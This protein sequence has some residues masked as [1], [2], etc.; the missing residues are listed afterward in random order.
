[1]PARQPIL[2]LCFLWALGAGAT[3][4][5]GG[6][7]YYDHLGGNEYRVVM[8]LYRDCG[9][10]NQN[11]TGFDSPVQI[12]FFNS[13]GAMVTSATIPYSGETEVPVELN[14]P[15]LAAPPQVCVATTVYEATVN[16]PPIAGGYT[17]AYHRCCRTPGVD[18]LLNPNS[19]GLTCTTHIPGPPDA[20]NSSPRF[21]GYPSIALCVGENMV[22]DHSATD[23][24]GDEL[25][26]ELCAPFQGGSQAIPNPAPQPPPYN[27]V[28]WGPGYSTAFQVDGAP[29]LAID[30]STGEITVHPT[31]QG[32]YAVG[33][34][35]KEIRNGVQIGETRRDFMFKTVVCDANIL[36]V[37]AEQEA[38]AM[39]DLTQQFTNQSV[40]SDF[41][42][43]DFGDPST[44]SDTSDE[45]EPS[46][47]YSAPGTY[48]VTLVAN[49]GW[50][51]ADT[52]ISVYQVNEPVT[53]AFVPPEPMC[54]A[55]Q[56]T[57]EATG[58]FGASGVVDWDLGPATPSVAQ[59]TQVTAMFPA[60]GIMPVTVTATDN[61]CSATFTADVEVHLVPQPAI[62]PQ[63]VFC[64][65]LTMAF[66]NASQDAATYAWDFGDASTTADVSDQFEP[67]W[68][69]AQPGTYTVTLTGDPAGI[70]PVSTTSVFHVYTSLD[71]W[72]APAAILCPGE[73]V[74]IA[75]SGDLFS[76]NA[77]VQ[78]ELGAAG[79]PATGMAVTTSFD[80]VGLHPV[81]VTVSENGCTGTYTDEVEVHPFPV[82]DFVSSAEVCAGNPVAFTNTSTAWTPMT[83]LW[84]FG[85]G[86]SATAEH[87]E[88]RYDAP[89]L[90]TVT[91]TVN[92]TSGCIAERT[93]V[94]PGQVR[95]H[96]NPVAAFTALPVT[97]SILDPWIDVVDHAN[98]AVLWHYTVEESTITDPSFAY[99]FWDGGRFRIV[100][101]V[102]T[103]HGCT[104]TT[105]R[106]VY[107]TDH[108]FFAPNAFTPD[109]DGRNDT[110]A[111]LVRGARAYD[112][113]IY[114][115]W[116]VERF[117]TTDPRAEWTGDGLPQ[118]V[119][120]YVAR[121]S[122]HGPLDKQYTGHVTLLR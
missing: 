44:T 34:R 119:F 109:G 25:V 20:N 67:T 55:Q 79:T 17:L 65:S 14:N 60:D 53:V 58:S 90:F 87:P 1:M 75:V 23:P 96:P 27:E 31:M 105:S 8:V 97:V 57:L 107:V 113:V 86:G 77:D 121:I 35:V 68:T 13:A 89:G 115:R 104:D 88:H 46:W 11:Q 52:S 24:D 71:P 33:V 9:P 103:E 54:G 83:Y 15:C 29:P 32:V 120:T 26:Y 101:T 3:H 81:T 98:G 51:C 62:V 41:W 47:T 40:N 94:R 37:V 64:G 59:G 110:F 4:I 76:P 69:Y 85:D 56:I 42:H 5:V 95:I 6:E 108:L 49:P 100:Q 39:C 48:S 91:L 10:D 116:G 72:F 7:I 18:N 30:A 114:D 93:L 21:N 38:A 28:V 92:T 73:D 61:G 111:P 63:Q 80:A 36:S 66:G 2:L 12:G 16:L 74:T 117:R 43:W 82:P 118:G 50:P 70:C 84:D 22:F 19:Q 45:E 102:T 106:V 78:W 122:E 112:L 99:E